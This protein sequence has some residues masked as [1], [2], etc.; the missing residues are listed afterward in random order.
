M[1]H[2]TLKTKSWKFPTYKE[3]RQQS[4][5]PLVDR[6]A[7]NKEKKMRLS[8]QWKA[9][10]QQTWKPPPISSAAKSG[11]ELMDITLDFSNRRLITVTPIATCKMWVFCLTVRAQVNLEEFFSNFKLYNRIMLVFSTLSKWIVLYEK[12]IIMS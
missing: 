11:H 1:S 8:S 10:S 5:N 2:S 9:D 4:H 6:L 7:A 12:S 3:K